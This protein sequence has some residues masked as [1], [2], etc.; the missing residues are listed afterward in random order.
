MAKRYTQEDLGVKDIYGGWRESAEAFGK[1]LDANNKKIVA[2]ADAVKKLREAN[3]KGQKAIDAEIIARRE[4]KKL[5]DKAQVTDKAQLKL[6]QQENNLREKL[7]QT[8]AGERDATIKLQAEIAKET[9]AKRKSAKESLNQLNAFQKLTKAT[10]EAQMKFKTL[11]AQYGLNDKRTR[12][13]RREFEKL[14]VKLRSVNAAARDGRRDVGRYGKALQGLRGNAMRVAGIFGAGIGIHQMVSFT[15]DSISAFRQQEKAIAQVEAGLEATGSTAGFTSQEFQKMASN[16][17]K[18]TLFGDEQILQDATA[19]LLTFTNISGEQFERTQKAALDLATRL[20]GDLKSA[21]IQLG[22]ALNDPVANL[23]ALSRSGIQFSKEQ[24]E[25]IKTLAESGRLAEAQSV[26]LDELNKQY[27]GSAEA[28]AEADGGMTQL[29]NAIGDAKE[30][31]GEIV[32][33]GLRPTIKSLKEFFENLS[34]EDIRSFVK[35][36]GTMLGVIGRLARI[37][38]IWRISTS[39]LG[40]IYWRTFKSIGKIQL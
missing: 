19:Q 8:K 20:D 4:L 15:K 24:K 9:A 27:G 30:K 33:E 6:I 1:I 36:L 32:L 34:E 31:F 2:E 10:N 35:T 38:V 22:K 14:D 26:I 40:K 7:R 29:S 21:S 18:T 3:T 13:A 25:V 23:S 16:L 17:Q 11:A 39:K 37:Y 5:T 28:A 12:A